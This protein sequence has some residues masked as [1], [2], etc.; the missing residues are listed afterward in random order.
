MSL[1]L[2]GAFASRQLYICIATFDPGWCENI[3]LV[4]WGGILSNNRFEEDVITNNAMSSDR[5]CVTYDQ[6]KSRDRNNSVHPVQFL[7]AR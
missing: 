3:Q 2:D 1:L 7:T 4:R 5:A 6:N